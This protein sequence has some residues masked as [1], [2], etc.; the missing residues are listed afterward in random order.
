MEDR[1]EL[2]PDDLV[3]VVKEFIRKR[4]GERLTI[5]EGDWTLIDLPLTMTPVGVLEAP[6]LEFV[7]SRAA[8]AGHP[9]L[10][11]RHRRAA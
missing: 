2:T 10:A 7:R 5:R 11:M 9:R 6:L 8:A 1:S 4:R 3:A